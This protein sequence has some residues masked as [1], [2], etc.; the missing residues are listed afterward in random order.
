M[1]RCFR[2]VEVLHDRLDRYSGSASKSRNQK[3]GLRSSKWCKDE[4]LSRNCGVSTG[5]GRRV[6]V[7]AKVSR[8]PC[9]FAPRGHLLT[10]CTFSRI[11]IRS[12]ACAR[13]NPFIG[14]R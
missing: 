9:R 10:K 3:A 5:L 13:R 14:F 11:S 8:G 6:H 4:L 12:G 1:G 2:I 7:F